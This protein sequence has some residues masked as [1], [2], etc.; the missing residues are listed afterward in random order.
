MVCAVGLE[1]RPF[2]VEAAMK[3]FTTYLVIF[4]VGLLAIN[5]GLPALS[6]WLNDL[7]EAFFSLK[8]FQIF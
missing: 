2:L 6:F 5:I 7:R 1:R 8:P 4:V 3:T